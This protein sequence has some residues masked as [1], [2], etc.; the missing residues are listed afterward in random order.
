MKKCVNCIYHTSDFEYP[1]DRN[2][3]IT[4][5]DCKDYDPIDAEFS[6][7]SIDDPDIDDEDLVDSISDECDEE[8]TGE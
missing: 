8:T 6:E 4:N 2:H 3:N 7:D 5:K 1:C